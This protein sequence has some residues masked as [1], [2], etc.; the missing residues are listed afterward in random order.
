VV[1]LLRALLVKL[2][3]VDHHDGITVR[4]TVVAQARHERDVA[5]GKYASP[6]RM[7]YVE[8]AV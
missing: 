1:A 5:Y 2:L 4:D 6:I 3:F 8:P 7:R